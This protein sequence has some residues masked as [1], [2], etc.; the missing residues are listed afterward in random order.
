MQMHMCYKDES[1]TPERNGTSHFVLLGVSVPAEQW[2][3]Y[4]KQ[5]SQRCAQYGL[6]DCEVHAA[7]MARRYAEQEKT[8]DFHK[9]S[10]DERRRSVLAE[11]QRILIAI[12]AGGNRDK[13]KAQRK[14]FKE[15]DAYVHLTLAERRECL[16]EL[17]DVVGGWADARIF[18]EAIC[19]AHFIA[20]NV[21]TPMM[22][23]AFTEVVQRFEYFL[24]NRGKFINEQLQGLIVQDNN[25][26][27]AKRLTEMMKRFHRQGTKWTNIHH[28]IETPLFV[29]SGLTSM[30]QVADL[31]AY[32]TR[33][34]FENKERDLFDRIY[35]RFDRAG[36]AVVGI[37]HFADDSCTCK[38]CRD[39]GNVRT[40]PRVP[41]IVQPTPP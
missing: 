6:S 12:T 13:L 26:T 1:G 30:V 4:D 21:Q 37:R 31:C 5:I 8:P 19:K 27:V 25:P 36:S 39:H 20:E 33:R 40:L 15:T 38:V 7:W 9:L 29:D 32:A 23:H 18:C 17:A 10:R 24:K 35:P 34:F 16:R 2:K 3:P 41:G 11:R 14:N 28:I 22:E